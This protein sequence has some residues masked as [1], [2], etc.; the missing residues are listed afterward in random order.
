[1]HDEKPAGKRDV[2]IDKLA[3]H[4]K[5]K[6]TTKHYQRIAAS[7]RAVGLREPLT[8]MDEDGFYEI[9]DGT[10]RYEILQEMGVETVSCFVY[11]PPSSQ[12]GINP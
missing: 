3:R 9:L 11:E 8:V 7:L 5:H 2:P 10:L 1:M 6:T 4:T 12:P